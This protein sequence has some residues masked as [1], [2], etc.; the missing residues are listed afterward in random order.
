MFIQPAILLALLGP[1]AAPPAQEPEFTVDFSAPGQPIPP[2]LLYG[3]NDLNNAS[4]GVWKA[5]AESVKPHDGL[6]RIWLKYHLGQLN[7]G[8]FLACQR[9]QEAGMSIMLT[10]TGKPGSR[11]DTRQGAVQEAPDP[12]VM[13]DQTAADVAK[14]LARGLPITHVELWNE[15]DMPAQWGGSNEEF[16]LF[17]AKTCAL[18]RPQLDAK[19]KL[20]GPGMAANY[21]GGIRLFRLITAACKQ[22]GFKPDFLSWHD[23][24]GFPM[25]QYYHNTARL[26]TALAQQDGLG[27]PEL[28]LSEWNAGLPGEKNPFHEADDYRGAANFVSMTTA[29]AATPVKHSLFFMLQDGNWDTRQDFAGEAVGAFT[30]HGAPKSV[31]AGMRMMSTAGALPRVPVTPR[32]EL[33]ANFSLLATRQGSRGYLVA[34]SCFGKTSGHV[35]KMAEAAGVDLTTLN[36]LE[37][38]LKR[39]VRGD[40]SYEATG[41]PAQDKPTWERIAREM[42]ALAKE[43]KESGRRL[44]VR[45]KGGPVKVTGAWVIDATHGNPAADADFRKRFGP[46]EGGWF[47]VAAQ[48]TLQQLRA[49]GVPAAELERIEAALKDKKAGGIQGVSEANAA[50]ARAIFADMQER[51]EQDPPRELARH[52][53]A[54][55]GKVPAKDW[56]E[57]QGD[58]LTLRLPPFTSLMLEVSWDPKASEDGQ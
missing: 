16:A 37:D 55:P 44:T 15:P 54:A 33:P 3:M 43:E 23:Y 9:A 30:L 10:V 18:L 2:G 53:A 14:L 38:V 25:D 8:H 1:P 32:A 57:M 29:L 20:G 17:W 24:S 6:V 22:A 42:R 34:A 19:I 11:V 12:K 49:E 58:L 36:K 45:M 46:Y 35:R 31:L 7:D 40:A 4:P 52:P 39:Y 51:A 5:W 26:V 47:A 21:G 41:L 56:A 13:A 50:R 48:L 28:I 27:T